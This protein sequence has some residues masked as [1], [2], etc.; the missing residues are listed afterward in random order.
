MSGRCELATLL[1][2][3]V[4]VGTL[5]EVMVT[6]MTLDSRDAGPGDL[7]LAVAGEQHHGRD[8]LDG[9]LAAG[10]AAVVWEPAPGVDALAIAERCAAAGVP[11]V[12]L[13]RLRARAGDLAA[14]FYGNPS[15]DLRIVGVT[16]TDGKTSVAH[17]AAQLLGRLDGPAAVLGTLGWGD[18]QTPADPGLTTPDPVTLQSRLAALRHQGVRSVAME[19][20]SHA[21]AQHRVDAVRFDTAILTYVGR[22]HLDYHGSI[23][24]YRAAKRRLFVQPGLGRCVL[25]R[26]DAL[27]AELL[28]AADR[29]APAITYG[30]DSAADVWLRRI[31]PEPDGLLVDAV[32]GGAEG[33]MRLPLLGGFNAMNAFAALTA[34]AAEPTL[35]EAQDMLAELRPVPGRMECFGRPGGPLA[36]VDYAHTPGALEA[37]LA[38]LRAH[39]G[40]GRLVCVLGCGGE[41]DRGKRPLMGAVAARLADQVI[42][43]DD[44]PRSEDPAAIRAEL[45]GACAGRVDCREIADRE[46]AIATAI[47]AALPGD[48]VLVAG[49]GHETRQ[50]IGGRDVPFSD[51]EV[52]QR[53]IQGGGG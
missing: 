46:A 29:E 4:S 6:G 39:A 41:R 40:K 15:A 21:L 5:P 13:E 11:A 14:R 22:D 16:G 42:V 35:A 23:D 2:P 33:R 19:V 47:A 43:T 51:R 10:V 49:K 1:A 30:T 50:I 17:Y 8:Y 44:N 36:V 18:D 31:T 48:L 27:G 24:A 25:N 12:A 20:S 9:A 52:V 26:D 7:F 38:A 3:S 45:L 53:L 28:T 32:V 34:A 37:A